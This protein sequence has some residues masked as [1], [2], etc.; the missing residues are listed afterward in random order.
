MVSVS[1]LIL[2]E[3]GVKTTCD[4]EVLKAISSKL[5]DPS[6]LTLL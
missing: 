3:I 1:F 5:K 2:P 6:I 4:P